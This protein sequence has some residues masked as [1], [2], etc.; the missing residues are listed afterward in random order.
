MQRNNKKQI[1]DCIKCFISLLIVEMWFYLQN[2]TSRGS[3]EDHSVMTA[4]QNQCVPAIHFMLSGRICPS[5][6]NV[7]ML[8][9]HPS[10]RLQPLLSC[11]S[12]SNV[13]DFFG[14][15]TICVLKVEL[16]PCVSEPAIKTQ[17]WL[18]F[19]GSLSSF[20]TQA[21]GQVL[22][23]PNILCIAIGTGQCSQ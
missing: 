13:D 6:Q 9:I 8:H 11:T 17:H 10:T 21:L 4:H 7:I 5:H 16:K 3:L 14:A 19:Q 20:S 15:N 22:P 18:N 2:E 1:W 23:L 12:Q